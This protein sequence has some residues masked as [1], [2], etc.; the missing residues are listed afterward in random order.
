MSSRPLLVDYFCGAGGASVGYARAGF[1]VVGVDNNKTALRRYPFESVCADAMDLL[2][3]TEWRGR[4]IAV[5]AASPPC[6]PYSITRHSHTVFYPALIGPVRESLTEWGG[7]YVIENVEGAPLPGAL[8]ICG[9]QL[10]AH[11][12]ATGLTLRLRRHR[13]FESNVF[14][15]AEPCSCDS[16]PVGGAYGGGRRDRKL[17]LEVRRGGYTPH[18]TVRAELLGIDWMT[19]DQLSQAIPPAYTQFIGEQLIERLETL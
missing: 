13:L 17:A 6:Q 2:D 14:M 5:K 15:L 12:P 8:T 7:P 18:K 10:R 3:L 4:P 11:D 16:T 1:D 9:A 19:R